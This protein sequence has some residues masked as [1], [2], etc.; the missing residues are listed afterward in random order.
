[1]DASPN[2]ERIEGWYDQ[3]PHA[4]QEQI[5]KDVGPLDQLSPKLLPIDHGEG[6]N[7]NLDAAVRRF[8]E[9]ASKP[10]PFYLA[11]ISDCEVGAIGAGFFAQEPY[12]GGTQNMHNICGFDRGFLP[13]RSEL[14]DAF[15]WAAL[16][17]LQQN[18]APWRTNTAA[19]FKLL[20]WP[21]PHPRGVEIHL[22]Y[23]LLVDG[24]LFKFLK[25]KRV[26]LLGA[27]APRL[28]R[29]WKEKRFIEAYKAFGPVHEVAS[30]EAFMLPGRGQNGGAWHDIERATRDVQHLKFD[31]ALL[32][33]GTPA[34]ILAK[35]ICS[36]GKTAL[37][38]G[39]VFDALLG[40]PE[41][42]L[43]PCMRD[44]HWPEV[45]W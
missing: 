35:R 21:V 9:L 17:G 44:V 10:E 27:L 12:P 23:R 37:D 13:Y 25:G 24:G 8:W 6:L 14:L 1:M 18:W 30:V 2:F 32:S 3:L 43:R 20:G 33:A 19:V 15:R 36:L 5:R 16:L 29:A 7:A 42:K 39:F 28:E 45:R 11:R 31:V 40:D 38:V 34:K 41:R 4:R 26:L 22:P